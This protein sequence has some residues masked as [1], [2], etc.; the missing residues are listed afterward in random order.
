MVTLFYQTAI[1]HVYFYEIEFAK[2]IIRY[3]EAKF[4][5]ESSHP[6]I[7]TQYDYGTFETRQESF[8]FIVTNYMP[9]TLEKRMERNDIDF[10][11]KVK[12]ACQL[13]SA[14]SFLQK[15][16]IIH[17]DIKPNNI[18]IS[19]NNAILG[20]F[21]LIKEL[22]QDEQRIMD[23]DINLINETIINN[24]EGYAAMARYYRTLE[25]VNYANHK[26]KLHIESDVFQL[27]LVLAKLFT[28]ENPLKECND[29]HSPIELNSVG[30]V[31]GHQNYGRIIHDTICKM[32]IVD[33]KERIPIDLVVDKFTGIY[34][35]L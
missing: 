28:G 24:E 26:D 14:I 7:L 34:A 30:Y 21:G 33:Y 35:E 11:F 27:G 29:L 13:L 12:Y 18:F 10:A 31:D 6:A 2:L 22:N 23:D 3:Q 20:D 9:E 4:L 16:N 25:L 1:D 15:K 8:P 17:R 5:Q 32:L 19:N